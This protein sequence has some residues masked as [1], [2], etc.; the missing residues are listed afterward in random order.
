MD[1]DKVMK[2]CIWC[3]KQSTSKQSIEHIIPESLGCPEAFVLMDG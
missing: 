2:P 3:K 1:A